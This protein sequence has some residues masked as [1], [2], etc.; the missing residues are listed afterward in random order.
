MY[1]V[2]GEIQCCLLQLGVFIFLDKNI[3][4]G[5]R[6]RPE[7]RERLRLCVILL[8]ILLFFE[9]CSFQKTHGEWDE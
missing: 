7:I 4:I 1:S 3:F 2:F 8:S 9:L 5:M 6:L